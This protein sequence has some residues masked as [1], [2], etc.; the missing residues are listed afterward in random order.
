MD[1]FSRI[2]RDIKELRIQ[3]AEAVARAALEAL[4]IRSDR[5]A[6]EVLTGLRPT[7]P[8]LRNAIKFAS[9]DP[10]ILAAKALRLFDKAQRDTAAIGSQKI[11]DGMKVFTHCHSSTVMGIL[12]EAKRQ[13]RKFEVFCTETRPLFQG[14]KTAA[15]LAL[16]GIPVTLFVDSAA[17]LALKRCDIFLMGADCITAEGKTINKIGSG[18]FCEIAN[19]Y[20]TPA[21]SC[22]SSWKF[23]PASVFGFEE[24]I[25]RRNPRE[26][27]DRPPRGVRI[28][29]PA[30]E[31]IS[32]DL[33]SGII[34][35]LGV[36]K[37]EAFVQE[38]RDKQGWM[39]Q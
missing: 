23:D 28:M 32:P 24:P 19:K 21:Y 33:V 7:E 31:K 4:Q 11:Q 6:I 13:G 29:N 18:M 16:A 20:D 37:P 3:G 8:M 39:F 14:R 34:S 35:E 15:E 22:A 12:K 36:F 30:F 26:V 9:P 10:K 1:K 38:V 27:W 5:K 17:R 25:E 2:C